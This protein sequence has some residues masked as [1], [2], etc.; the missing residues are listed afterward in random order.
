MFHKYFR[1]V[2]YSSLCYFV[3][4][5]C[6]PNNS[7]PDSTFEIRPAR[8]IKITTTVNDTI[9][10]GEKVPAAIWY[11][12]GPDECYTLEDSSLVRN[13]S[14]FDF[15]FRERVYTRRICPEYSVTKI[16]S[17]TLADSLEPGSYYVMANKNTKDSLSY[18]FFVK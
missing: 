10:R 8:I 11:L 5:G 7:G 12:T 3:S 15:T 6:I 2:L 18:R 14:A 17:I 13:D 1:I 4:A 9:A 16:M